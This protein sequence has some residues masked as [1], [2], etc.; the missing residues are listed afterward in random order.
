MTA[1]SDT[2]GPAYFR[3][4][5]WWRD[6]TLK[7]WVQRAVDRAPDRPALIT[8]TAAVTYAE[9]NTRAR[10]IANGLGALG[11]RKGDVVGVRLP[12]LPEFVLTW[13][14]I[15]SLGAVMQTLHMAMASAKSRAFSSTAVRAL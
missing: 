9:M 13:L 8:T 12:N 7:D 15:N 11:I 10:Q 1:A 5:G 6:E 2:Y 3:A 4:R 14:A